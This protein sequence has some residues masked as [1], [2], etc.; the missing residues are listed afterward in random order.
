MQPKRQFSS[1]STQSLPWINVRAGQDDTHWPLYWKF[2]H[3]TH[4][5]E[6]PP[7]H[8]ARGEHCGWQALHTPRRPVLVSVVSA[9]S[10]RLQAAWQTFPRRTPLQTTQSVAEVPPGQPPEPGKVA[11]SGLQ[12]RHSRRFEFLV[13]V[14]TGHVVMQFPLNFQNLHALQS[15]P[16][17]PVQPPWHWEEHF[18]QT[19]PVASTYSVCGSHAAT[20]CPL[21]VK[22]EQALHSDALGPKQRR[23]LEPGAHSGWHGWQVLLAARYLFTGQADTQVLPSL[24]NAQAT[25]SLAVGPVQPCVSHVGWQASQVL[26][27]EFGN[28]VWRLQEDTQVTPT[29]KL[30]QPLSDA[31]LAMQPVGSREK[32]S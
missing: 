28:D 8:P 29:R 6:R 7:V 18:R 2:T 1:Q 16:V 32:Q 24:A 15:K 12:G 11:H 21:E 22:R 13:V 20:H 27:T 9:Y 31:F 17:G 25:Q 3:V 14:S 5:S 10:P 30:T 23:P 19:L 26:V 4:W